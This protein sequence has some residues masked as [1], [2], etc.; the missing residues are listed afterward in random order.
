MCLLSSVSMVSANAV[1]VMPDSGNGITPK[2]VEGNPTCEDLGCGEELRIQKPDDYVGT[3]TYT[4][5][6]CLEDKPWS[7]VDVTA[8]VLESEEV[9]INWTS[10]FPVNCVFM[11]GGNIGGNQYCY[12]SAPGGTSNGDTLLYTPINP[13][14]K[15]AG[16]SHINFCYDPALVPPPPQAPEFPSFALPVA[17]IVGIIG[18]VYTIKAREK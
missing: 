11:K 15:P 7:C 14:G 2:I 3:W 5:E 18:L 17:M 4:G 8:I 13:S 10:D 6:W 1:F 9:G 12:Q 16:I